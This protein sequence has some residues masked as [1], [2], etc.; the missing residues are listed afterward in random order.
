MIVF[1]LLITYICARIIEDK[2]DDIAEEFLKFAKDEK[3]NFI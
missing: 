3:L 2:R 1:C